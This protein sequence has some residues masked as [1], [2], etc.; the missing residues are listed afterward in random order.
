MPASRPPTP[1]PGCRWRRTIPTRNVVVESADPV[2]VL[3]L[4]RALTAF[5]RASPALTGGDYRSLDSGAEDVFA[6]LRTAGGQQVLV[7]LNFGTASHRLDFSAVAATGVIAVATDMRR[8]GAVDLAALAVGANEG[9][10]VLL[11]NK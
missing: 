7:V 5:R 3:S 6:Y 9:L 4:F 8:T 11:G 1:S 10:V 2:S